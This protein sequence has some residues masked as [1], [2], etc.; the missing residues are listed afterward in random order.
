MKHSSQEILLVSAVI[1]ICVTVALIIA[2]IANY[3]GL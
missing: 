1:V 2:L 3:K